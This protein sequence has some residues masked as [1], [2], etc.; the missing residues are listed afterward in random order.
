MK[1]KGA[2]AAIILI[3]AIG[4]I[5]VLSINVERVVDWEES[6][7]EKSTKPYGLS[8]F[9]KEL[10]RL[11][12]DKKI[13]T[14][15]HTPGTYLY[16]N[17][18]EGYGDHQ[19]QGLFIFIG[20]TNYIESDDIEELLYFTSGGNTVFISD[21][22]L[23]EQLLDTLNLSVNYKKTQDSTATFVFDS[24]LLSE[25]E[26]Q[27]DKLLGFNYFSETKTS[28]YK[29]LG[30]VKDSVNLS[31]FIEVPFEDGKLVFH[32]E[33]KAFT[34]YHLLKGERF[35]YVEGVLSALPTTDVYFDSYTKRYDP[36]YG[37]AEKRSNLS[38]FLEQTAF[39]W[40]WYLALLLTLLFM[41]FNAK[42]RQRIIKIIKPLENTTLGFIKTISNLYY[43]TEDYKNIINKKITYFLE[44]IRS[45]YNIDTSKLDSEFINLLVS[46]SGKKREVITKLIN[47]INWLN[48]KN[49]F[50]EENLIYLN[51]HIEAFYSK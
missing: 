27:L 15:Y 50:F 4:V 48:T 30:Y 32:L 42:R 38:W 34:N 24:G 37:D 3:I 39:R 1:N 9:Y 21:Y 6:F 35:R 33:P 45:E 13:R 2:L 16:A 23:P 29:N 46:K 7:N 20:N 11:F 28:N 8:V 49:E 40:A 31:N 26:T 5:Y 19:A 36:Y 47:Y 25:N 10:P 44:K 17:S 18:A 22:T 43:E 41:V 12:K 51:R 14:V